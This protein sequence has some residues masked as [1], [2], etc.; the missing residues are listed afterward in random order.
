MRLAAVSA[1]LTILAL[2]GSANAVQAASAYGGTNVWVMVGPPAVETLFT[3]GVLV[4]YQNT[5]SIPTQGIAVL[6]VRDSSGQMIGFGTASLD[7]NSSTSSPAFMVAAGVASG[8]YTVSIFA[9][10]FSGVALSNT[11]VASLTFT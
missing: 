1:A 5:L 2:V 4:T 9:M 10:S 3:Q 6:V 7:L 11:T 8:T